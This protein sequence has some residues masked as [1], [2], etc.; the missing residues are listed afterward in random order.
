M[1][2]SMVEPEIGAPS[3]EVRRAKKKSSRRHHRADEGEEEASERRRSSSRRKKSADGG[4]DS[5]SVDAPENGERKKK[6][7]KSK[8]HTN[9][10]DETPEEREERRRRRREKKAAKEAAAAAAAAAVPAID[11]IP[12]DRLPQRVIENPPVPLSDSEHEDVIEIVERHVVRQP[13]P[14]PLPPPKPATKPKPP[15]PAVKPKPPKPVSQPQP[16]PPP[17]RSQPPVRHDFSDEQS[18]GDDYRGRQ[19][20]QQQPLKRW[21]VAEDM[22]H[23]AEQRPAEPDNYDDEDDEDVPDEA[24][25]QNNSLNR[26]NH[27][28]LYQ[29]QQQQP[30]EEPQQQPYGR[31]G[32]P[33]PQPPQQQQQQQ[34]QQQPVQPDP[35]DPMSLHRYIADTLE[36]SEDED[37]Q[38]QKQ[39]QQQQQQHN[40]DEPGV[41]NNDY[42]YYQDRYNQQQQQYPD[43]QQQY[44]GNYQQYPDE[45]QQYPEHQQYPDDQQQ[46]PADPEQR[47]SELVEA[48]AEQPPIPEGRKGGGGLL[49]RL[50]SSFRNSKRKTSQRQQQRPQ[51][52]QPQGVPSDS[53][54]QQP[55]LAEQGKWRSNPSM[56]NANENA[57]PGNTLDP[58]LPPGSMQQQQQLQPPQPQ[59]QRLMQA[60]V[61]TVP[62]TEVRVILLDGEEIGVPLPRKATGAE[63]MARVCEHIDVQE[64]DYFGLTYVDAKERMWFWLD[65]EKKVLKQLKH[66]DNRLLNFQ[67]KFYPPEPNMLFADVTR[68]QLCLQVRQ[69]IYT[70]KLPCTWVTQALLGSFQ[71][72]SE[73]GDY[74]LAEHGEVDN[75]DYLQNFEFVHNQTP[76]L[77]RKIAEL[78]RGHKGVTPEVAD[79]RYLETA[80]RLEFYGVDLHPAR[81]LD[82]VDITIGVCFGGV[83][84]YKDRMRISRFA[85]PKIL[86]ISYRKN[87]FYLKIRSDLYDN[88]EAVV[89]FKMMNH[90]WAKRLWKIAIENHAFFRLKEAQLE[91]SG[92]RSS[93]NFIRGNSSHRFSGRTMH[94]YRTEGGT[95]RHSG[96]FDR[97]LTKRMSASLPSLKGSQYGSFHS[98]NRLHPRDMR[99]QANSGRGRGGVIGGSSRALASSGGGGGSGGQPMMMMARTGS[100]SIL[101]TSA[102]NR[103]SSRATSNASDDLL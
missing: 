85:W 82:D 41:A 78:H 81:D 15:P 1:A 38:L 4:V 9:R 62:D 46:Y 35:A 26:W 103:P 36:D 34:Q 73:L 67:V 72:Q 77:V 23:P 48:E 68:Y 57:T 96:T 91:K 19:Q 28:P 88:V 5:P 98:L 22:R 54:E 21:D 39:Q 7:K 79:L 49:G 65:N 102:F 30:R 55:G 97:S 100:V 20:Q 69:D 101:P 89:G 70:G 10:E 83:L 13:Q 95:L 8:H 32:V 80:R 29:Q 45:N 18:S 40:A 47:F 76:E 93:L 16:P 25:P 86:R 2:S 61:R 17:Q 71:V 14:P 12:D 11:D 66:C 75:I 52:Q 84:V 59:Q 74:D 24:V 37:R 3:D 50:F 99:P 31:R 51:Q 53:A 94:Q 63:L 64:T 60:G 44:P 87:L 58:R 43:D 90:K 27:Q 6:S 33:P 56:F 92:S 42:P